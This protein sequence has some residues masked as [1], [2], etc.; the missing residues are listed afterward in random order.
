MR[1]APVVKENAIVPMKL[2]NCFFIRPIDYG[3]AMDLVV[4][5]HY[6]HRKASCSYAFGLYGME[7]IKKGL[8]VDEEMLSLLGVICYGSPASNALCIGVCGK[9]EKNNVIEL[10][11]L[12]IQ[13][14]TPKN[15]E[16]FFIGNTLKLLDKEIVVSYSEPH[17][18]HMGVVYQASNFL[19]TGTSAKRRDRVIEGYTIHQRGLTAKYSHEDL[20]GRFGER[21]KMIVRPEK[22]RYVYFNTRNKKR[23][24]ELMGKLRYPIQPYPKKEEKECY[25]KTAKG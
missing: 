7:K 25:A 3:V 4:K 18:G 15:T 10:T 5:Y 1:K 22:H 9:E 23:K 19:Y 14:D 16:S 8:L 17:E 20:M 21:Q 2:K 24:K 11:R 12:W 6:L 13:D